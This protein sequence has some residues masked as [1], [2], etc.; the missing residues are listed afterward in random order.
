MKITSLTPGQIVYTVSKTKMGNTT[1]SSTSIHQVKILSINL[2]KGMVEAS[3]NCNGPRTYVRSQIAKW[4][5]KRPETK[6][7]AFGRVSLV[8]KSRIVK[9]A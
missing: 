2:E 9:E 7:D 3:W 1:I 6:T 5:L 8:K 4:K